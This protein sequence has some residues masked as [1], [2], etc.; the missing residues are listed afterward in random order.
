MSVDLVKYI[1]FRM[2][3]QMKWNRYVTNIACV[4]KHH[5]KLLLRIC[6][7][8]AGENVM[9]TGTHFEATLMA[10]TL[11]KE[12]EFWIFSLTDQNEFLRHPHKTKNKT[13]AFDLI[14]L[15]RSSCH[16]RNSFL[17][18]A[19]PGLFFHFLVLLTR[20]IIQLIENKLWLDSNCRSLVWEATRLPTN[21]DTIGRAIGENTH[22]VRKEKKYHCTDDLLFGQNWNQ[23]LCYVITRFNC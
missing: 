21:C 10:K 4:N 3:K 23:R 13:L 5:E 8:G 20:I 19:N 17:K 14:S 22:L 7:T 6:K 9:R 2:C 16:W 11:T 1:K 15:F 18:W 12:F